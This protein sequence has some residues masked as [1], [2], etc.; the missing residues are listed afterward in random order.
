METTYLVFSEVTKDNFVKIERS[1]RDLPIRIFYDPS[2]ELLI[3]KLMAGMAHKLVGNFFGDKIR[4]KVQS[5][6]GDRYA[7]YLMGAFHCTSAMGRKKE[8]DVALVPK[9]RNY[10]MDWPSIVIEVGVSESLAVL[11]NDAHF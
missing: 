5:R 1:R 6:S 2:M 3:V 7:L 10:K 9:N 8:S 4:D 11:K